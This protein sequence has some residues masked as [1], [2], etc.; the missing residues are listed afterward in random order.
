LSRIDPS[1]SQ[2]SWSTIPILDRSCARP[3]AAMSTPSS[4]IRPE[5][6]S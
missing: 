2:V 3:I 6:S 1:K 4:V 5:R